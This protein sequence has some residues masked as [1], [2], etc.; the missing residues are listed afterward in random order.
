MN[1]LITILMIINSILF[2]QTMHP[3]SMGLILLIQTLLT[4]MFTGFMTKSFWFSYILFLIFIGGMLIL[5][6]Y[7]SSLAS[8]EKFKFSFS[9]GMKIFMLMFILLLM[10][11]IDNFW[12]SP[13]TFNNELIN[14]SNNLCLMKENFLPVSKMYDNP[15]NWIVI[16]LIN[17][18]L[19][20]LII[21]VKITHSYSGPL[22]PKN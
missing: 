7:M 2:T 10:L 11:F 12:F 5:F 21:V 4:C 15:N 16:F 19:L 20:N 1:Q 14:L 17:Y 6:I 8:N 22:R 13:N 18:L 9:T 3:M